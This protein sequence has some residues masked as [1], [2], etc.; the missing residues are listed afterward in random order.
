[1]GCRIKENMDAAKIS[2][3]ALLGGGILILVAYGLYN[4]LKSMG[5]VDPV[6]FVAA[7]IIL[8]GIVILTVSTAMDRK[9]GEEKKI[10]KE[11]ME[12]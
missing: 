5:K 2:G 9:S 3:L 6:I 11:D 1:M 12:P 4:V 7:I 8:F 10:K